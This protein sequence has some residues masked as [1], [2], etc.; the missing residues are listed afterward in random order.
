[1][2]VISNRLQQDVQGSLV[3]MAVLRIRGQHIDGHV[4]AGFRP[5]LC[6]NV[7]C[8]GGPQNGLRSRGRR[9]ISERFAGP[10]LIRIAR[11]S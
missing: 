10:E 7:P 4:Y 8:C 11:S 2:R 1:V 5:R 3:V 6:K 9:R